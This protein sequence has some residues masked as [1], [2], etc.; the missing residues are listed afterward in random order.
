MPALPD[1]E[2]EDRLTGLDGWNRD[3]DEIVRTYELPSFPDAIDFVTRVAALAEAADHH[4]DIDI[5]YRKVRIALATHDQGGITDK[6]F[7]LAAQ[8]DA[9]APR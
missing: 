2:I 7:A 8:I 5:R 9:A 6:D 3:G 4:P 1:D